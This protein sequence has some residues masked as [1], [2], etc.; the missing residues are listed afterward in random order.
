[1]IGESAADSHSKAA[2]LPKIAYLCSLYPA[3]SHTFVLREINALRELGVDI[4]TFSIRR[5]GSDQ[6]LA[7]ADR[8]AF[9]STYAILPP[10]WTALF[11]AHLRLLASAPV[12]YLSTLALALR[13]APAGLRG[14]LW[15]LF[16]F[17]ES[18]V[19][20]AE[21]RR[22]GIRHIHVH[23]GNAASDIA[24]LTAHLGSALEPR[25]PWSWSFTLHGPDEL[26]D[27]SHSRLAEKVRRARF[28]VCI[29]D[30]TR[31]QLMTLS[32]PEMW[33]KLHVI[34]V[35][36]PI[37]QFTRDDNASLP[38]GDA[39]ILFI[40][41]HVPQKG[42]AV[43]I[44]ATELLAKRGHKVNLTLAGEGASRPAFERFAGQLGLA[45]QVSFPGAVGQEEIHDL[46]ASASI[47]CLP[48]FAEGLPGVLMEAMA[49]R[50]PVV[51]TRITG[52]PELVED[53][54]TG[55]LVAPGRPDVL[56]DALERLLGDPSLCRELGE[57]AREKVIREFNTE[58][59]AKQLYALFVNQLSPSDRDQIL[60]V[61]NDG[62]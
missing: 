51:S 61:A 50:L 17:V 26:F 53:G 2:P 18:V 15:Q 4:A 54:H 49:M 31:S 23:M 60:D 25:Q 35:G 9:E 5:A 7:H 16:Y 43:L 34:H 62:A 10:R 22:R 28:V 52:V 12:V 45:S 14:R 41:R 19:L 29:S 21:C 33:D 13:L 46:Y 58:N 42:H 57:R 3:V 44:E 59:S 27:V 30:Y 36:I 6:L 32:H 11:A 37:E 48:S 38:R 8:V 55:L 47:F 1:M 40:G 56:A 39:T 24:L 20:W